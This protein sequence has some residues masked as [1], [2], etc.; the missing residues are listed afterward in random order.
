MYVCV[1]VCVHVYIFAII[2]NLQDAFV[3]AAA[4]AAFFKTMKV[5][6]VQ[7]NK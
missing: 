4:A 6:D 7:T 1:G 2:F 5:Y 3:V